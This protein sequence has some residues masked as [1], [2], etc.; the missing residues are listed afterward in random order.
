MEGEIWQRHRKITAPSFNERISGSVWS[1]AV[2]QA[3][4]MLQSWLQRGHEGTKDTAGDSAL[5]A[6]HVLTYAGF[7]MRYSY[8]EGIQRPLPGFTMSYRD[9]L[10]MILRNVIVLFLVPRAWLSM[11]FMPRKLR[12]LGQATMEF[13][14]YMEEMLA[15]ERKLISKRDPGQ[16]NLMSALIRASEEANELR[17]NGSMEGLQDEE[18]F[19]NIFVYNLAGHETTANTVASAIVLLAAY[20]EWQD[21]IAEEIDIVF[22]SGENTKVVSYEDAFP[23]LRRCLAIMVL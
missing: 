2:Q 4:D 12:D 23:R 10:S 1:E 9:A 16:G 6:L 8:A 19:G 11:S 18:I 14:K 7:G 20:P 3:L 15:T 5:L 21:W 17:Q 13:Q 22:G